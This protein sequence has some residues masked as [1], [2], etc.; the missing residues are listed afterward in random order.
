MS[1]VQENTT[2]NVSSFEDINSVFELP[3][4][5][6]SEV[7]K[8]EH[9]KLLEKNDIIGVLHNDINNAGILVP[10]EVQSASLC[11]NNPALDCTS[12]GGNLNI[13]L[14]SL[15]YSDKNNLI[16]LFSLLLKIDKRNNS[17]LYKNNYESNNIS[18]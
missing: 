5:Q 9:Q 12:L 15:I 7:A 11:S 10:S 1:A 4:K 18:P 17:N 6:I 8:K 3:T 16:N 2:T 13:E 14:N